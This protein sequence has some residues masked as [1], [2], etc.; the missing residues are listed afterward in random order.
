MILSLCLSMIFSKNRFPP[1]GRGPRA[2]FSGYALSAE[3][4]YSSL[5][6]TLLAARGE[7]LA[8]GL[9]RLGDRWKSRAFT[10]G[11]I[12]FC[13]CFFGVG[14]LHELISLQRG[15]PFSYRY[16]KP[17]DCHDCPI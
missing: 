16:A 6:K 10:G 12:D 1:S 4:V 14:F 7:D 2:G 3:R 11:A 13:P 15:K 17:I 8:A 9:P 5:A